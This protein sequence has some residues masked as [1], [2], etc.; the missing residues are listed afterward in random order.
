MTGIRQKD[1]NVFT[2]GRADKKR[3]CFELPDGTVVKL[4]YFI[5]SV[6]E[7]KK[8]ALTWCA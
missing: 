3:T 1:I 2:E 4:N 5:E 8:E 7:A 6:R